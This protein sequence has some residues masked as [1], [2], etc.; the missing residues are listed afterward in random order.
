MNISN[1]INDSRTNQSNEPRPVDSSSQQQLGMTAE[2][3]SCGCPFA[4]NHETESKEENTVADLL[5]AISNILRKLL[6]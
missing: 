3:K 6:S 4:G 1:V 2:P 5:Q